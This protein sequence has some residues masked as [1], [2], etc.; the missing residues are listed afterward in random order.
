MKSSLHTLGSDP[1]IYRLL[2]RR[3]IHCAMKLVGLIKLISKLSN[4]DI[5]IHCATWSIQICRFFGHVLQ[6]KTIMQYLNL[7]AN[8]DQCR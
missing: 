3:V 2:G 5:A 6:C 4:M 8:F 7:F 1:G